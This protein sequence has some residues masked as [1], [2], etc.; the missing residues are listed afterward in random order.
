LS[1]TASVSVAA[2]PPTVATP[3]NASPSPVTGTTTNLSVLGTDASGA[4]SLTYTWSVVSAPAG[5]PAPT[6]S[7]NGTNAAQNSTGTFYQAGSY[8]FRV[9]LADPAGLTATSSV[10]VSVDQT[11][12]K[13]AVT[14]GNASLPDGTSQQ[15]A[16][17]ALDQFG[18]SLATQPSF[19]WSVMSGI[20]VINS[21]GMYTAPSSGTGSATV[22]AAS[23]TMS[24]TASVTVTAVSVPG[25]PTNMTAVAVSKNQVNLSW[26]EASTSV[27]GFN[28]QRSSNGG[29]SW[30]QI[31]QVAGTVTTY[32]DTTVSKGKTYQYKVDAF[33]SAGTSAWSTA[34]TVS[35]PLQA[36]SLLPEPDVPTLG[37]PPAAPSNLTALAV[38]SHQVNLS[39]T[40]NSTDAT[41]FVI[42][43][44][45]ANGAWTTIAGVDAGVTTFSD[46]TVKPTQTYQYRVFATNN[47]TGNSPFS[48]VTQPVCPLSS[49]KEGIWAFPFNWL[50]WPAI[51]NHNG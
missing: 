38:S 11:L 31:A 18:K 40:D 24:G 29:K 43:R 16:A 17:T 27:N 44:L 32:A 36:P 45:E 7:A 25:T 10:T 30:V 50:S 49:V 34:V 37:L 1:A 13:L 15:F 28:I 21:G 4:S 33:N 41:G 35:T 46:T 48:N 51:Q 5:A 8:T 22:G 2:S 12:T 6:F 19:S 26:T 47:D 3:A 23:G 9:T 14:P 42:Q 20:G 39:W